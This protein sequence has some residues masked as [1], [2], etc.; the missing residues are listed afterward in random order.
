M[1]HFC[2]AI[3]R[4]WEE[5]PDLGFVC[6]LF[7]C[8]AICRFVLVGNQTDPILVGRSPY[9]TRVSLMQTSSLGVLNLKVL[10]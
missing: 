8:K 6:A 7:L 2:L 3:D 1:L 4:V 10:A 9:G 5:I